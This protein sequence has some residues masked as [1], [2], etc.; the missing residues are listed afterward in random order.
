ML[1]INADDCMIEPFF[2]TDKDNLE[3]MYARLHTFLVRYSFDQN[4]F[5]WGVQIIATECHD[6]IS[7]ITARIIT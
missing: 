4:I 6:Y 7:Q 3:V 2:G 1:I 5:M